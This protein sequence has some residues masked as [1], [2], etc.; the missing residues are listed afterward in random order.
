[1]LPRQTADDMSSIGQGSLANAPGVAAGAAGE[2]TGGTQGGKGGDAGSVGDET[3]MDPTAVMELLSSEEQFFDVLR[4]RTMETHTAR[5]RAE[6]FARRL[7]QSKALRSDPQL[8]KLTGINIIAPLTRWLFQAICKRL[9]RST[10]TELG[11]ETA[12]ESREKKERGAS[13]HLALLQH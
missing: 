1:M 8:S 4:M 12:D 13:N 2:G 5:G 9:V 11:R 6:G 3:V 7:W 10:P